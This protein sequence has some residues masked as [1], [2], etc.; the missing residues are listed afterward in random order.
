M[1]VYPSAPLSTVLVV[2]EDCAFPL[3]L[4]ASRLYLD[5]AKIINYWTM[6]LKNNDDLNQNPSLKKALKQLKSPPKVIFAENWS[7]NKETLLQDNRYEIVYENSSGII[8][9]SQ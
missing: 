4:T 9:R 5:Q 6:S 7:E 2:G 8:A 1:T 3:E